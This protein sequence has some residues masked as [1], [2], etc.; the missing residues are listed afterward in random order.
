V[1]TVV[2][3]KQWQ[4]W[5]ILVSLLVLFGGVV[6]IHAQPGYE[7]P[8]EVYVMNNPPDAAGGAAR[9]FFIDTVTGD[10]RTVDVQGQRFTIVGEYVI[11]QDPNTQAIYR[12]WMDGRVEQHPFIQPAPQTRYIDWVVSPNHEW[13]AWM[14]TNQEQGGLQTI[15]TLARAD[16]TE[17][18]VIL[19][20]GPDAF[21]RAVPI[22]LT[23]NWTFFFDRQPQ[24]V[25][26]YFFY[27]QYASIYKLEAGSEAPQPE[28][29]P[30]EPNCFCGAGIA[31]NGAYFARLEQV[32]EAGGYDVRLWD[33]A[34]DVDTFA[35]S[36]N[37]NYDSAGAVLVSPDG[38]RVVYS[39]ANDVAFDSAG[40]G[41]ERFMLA[42]MDV[43]AGGEQRAVLFNP[44]LVPLLP[45]AWTED[46]SG[47]LLYNPRQDGTWKLTVDSGEIRQVAGATWLGTM[48]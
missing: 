48:A 8:V 22:A 21:I 18:R 45:L 38:D 31:S 15:T 24:G 25:G 28:L 10:I 16:G 1:Q 41:R 27:R 44:L 4:R 14:L 12:A 30:F 33:L 39:L 7:A 43:A 13:I 2:T 46:G 20:D 40:S 29:L 19:T 34:A 9:L 17:P 36:I 37:V 35:R 6:P 47:V 11:F 3:N 26:E 5:V 23:D 32:S 42:V